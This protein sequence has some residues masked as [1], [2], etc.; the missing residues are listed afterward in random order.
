MNKSIHYILFFFFICFTS[1]VSAQSSYKTVYFAHNS[2]RLT[3]TSLTTLDEIIKKCQSEPCCIAIAAFTTRSGT[4]EYNYDLA[5][6]RATAV[7]EYLE[8]KSVLKPDCSPVFEFG[9]EVQ[10][11]YE[12]IHHWE[13]KVHAQQRCVD[14]KID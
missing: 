4:I 8:K 1:V 12:N 13:D 10:Y 5:S 3:K 6:K 7:R 11:I 9:E 2:Y 14:I